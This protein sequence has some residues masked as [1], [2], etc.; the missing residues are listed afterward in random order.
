MFVLCPFIC[1]W[2]SWN[3]CLRSVQMFWHQ[4]ERCLNRVCEF[5][6]RLLTKNVPHFSDLFVYSLFSCMTCICK[7]IILP[8]SEVICICI[9]P[10]Y[11][12]IALAC[13]KNIL[14]K[15]INAARDWTVYMI[16]QLQ[17]KSA[18]EQ[19]SHHKIKE[20]KWASLCL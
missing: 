2:W 16:K 19:R 18:Y 5:E 14:S 15:A 7:L 17:N 1:S 4:T 12:C 10:I 11:D 8:L 3:A 13:R 6:F 20:Y 9:G